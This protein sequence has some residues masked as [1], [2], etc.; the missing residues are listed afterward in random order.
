MVTAGAGV[1]SVA[2]CLICF[3]AHA[4]SSAS[5]FNFCAP[6]TSPACIEEAR[7]ADEK[8]AC[9]EIMRAYVASVFEYRACLEAETTRAVLQSNDAIDRWRCRKQGQCRGGAGGGNVAG[10]SGGAAGGGTSGA[11]SGAAGIGGGLKLREGQ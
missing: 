2:C 5:G 10:A 8:Q 1:C 11:S 7:T 4:Q 6:P 3:E 9:D